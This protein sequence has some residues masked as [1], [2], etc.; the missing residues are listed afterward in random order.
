MAA[1]VTSAPDHGA[2]AQQIGRKVA[3]GAAFM[4]LGRLVVRS[5]S[6]VSTLLLVRLLEPEDFG[7]IALAG[8]AVAMADILTTTGYANV[9]VRRAEVERSLYD[10]AWTMNVLRCLMLGALVALTA[11]WQARLLGDARLGPVM[12]VIALTIMLDGLT[13]VGLIRLQRELRFD[14]LFRQQIA[15]R[16]LAFLAAVTLAWATGSYWCLVVG[17]LISKVVIVP[18]SYWLAPHRPRLCLRHWRELLSFSK[19]MFALNLCSLADGQAPNLIIGRILGIQPVG[20]YNVAF[21]IAATPVTE[22]AVPI[23]GPIYAGYARVLHD[24]A[25]LR[26]QFVDGFGLLAAV[27]LPLSVGIALVAPEVERLALGPAWSGT[28]PVIALCALYALVDAMAHFTFNIFTILDRQRRLAGIYAATVAIRLPAVVLAALGSGL[29]GVMAMLLATSVLNLVVW[30]WQASRLLGLHGL[31][32]AAQLWRSVAAA[33]A[34]AAVVAASRAWL[35]AAASQDDALGNL[36][37]LAQL[38]LLGAAVHVGTQGL[39]WRLA[40]APPGAET[41]L[42]ATAMRV[43]RRV[44]A[45]LRVE[46][47]RAAADGRGA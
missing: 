45:V 27:L 6:V 41:Q 33:A 40:G 26:R 10:T 19:W 36:R 14:L 34:M 22:L 4:V 7:L 12:Q 2:A 46:G 31:A 8:A 17:N 35:P 1:P 25:L 38:A 39:L 21:Q 23:R 37:L 9:L 47:A 16:L 13:S 44:R 5:I 43:L 3:V 30:F 28:A 24:A 29:V 20:T 42:A 32:L 18:C 11:D 15:F